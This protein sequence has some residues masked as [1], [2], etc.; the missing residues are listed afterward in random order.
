MEKT[1]ILQ[2]IC[3]NWTGDFAL[4]HTKSPKNF[5]LRGFFV[6]IWP[7]WAYCIENAIKTMTS[8]FFPKLNVE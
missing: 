5:Q 4:F 3:L 8:Y 6:M 1:T 2:M 7:Y